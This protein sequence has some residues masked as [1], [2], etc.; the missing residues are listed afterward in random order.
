ME[1]DITCKKEKELFFLIFRK[2]RT[3]CITITTYSFF[4]FF[5]I[6]IKRENL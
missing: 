3:W 6:I 5:I 2:F 4:I 1:Q